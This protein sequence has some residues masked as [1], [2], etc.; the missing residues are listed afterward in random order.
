MG[1][2]PKI[3]TLRMPD[4]NPPSSRLDVRDGWRPIASDHLNKVVHQV[5]CRR[6]HGSNS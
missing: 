6:L 5:T 2:H 1:F 3:E 4:S